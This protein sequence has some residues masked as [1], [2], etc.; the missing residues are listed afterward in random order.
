M[1]SFLIFLS[2]VVSAAVLLYLRRLETR[3]PVRQVLM[4]LTGVNLDQR[5]V[6]NVGAADV[7]VRKVVI[8]SESKDELSFTAFRQ[9]RLVFGKQIRF[10]VHLLNEE[11]PVRLISGKREVL[12]W[13]LK[14]LTTMAFLKSGGADAEN[15]LGVVV[16]DKNGAAWVVTSRRAIRS[17][18][19]ICTATGCPICFMEPESK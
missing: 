7:V 4:S 13:H 14:G 19:L 6:V 5:E 3:A 8:E 12:N 9:R 16:F 15:R 11:D 18:R 1:A 2:I 10:V 17:G